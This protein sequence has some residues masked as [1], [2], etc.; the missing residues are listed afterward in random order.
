M[1]LLREINIFGA[2]EWDEDKDIPDLT[3]KVAI[4]TGGAGGCGYRAAIA[5]LKKNCKVIIASRSK[6]KADAAIKTLRD[7]IKTGDVSFIRVDLGDLKTIKPFAEE[8]ARSSSSLDI[9]INNAGVM[10]APDGSKTSDGYEL[11]I[12]TNVIGHFALFQALL[13]ILLVTARQTGQVRIVNVS[14]F[15]H[16]FASRPPITWDDD[17]FWFKSSGLRA[18]NARYAA[19]KAGNV[20]INTKMHES[21]G[22]HGLVCVS[23]HPGIINTDL[24]RQITGLPRWFLNQ[25]IFQPAE[26]GGINITCAATSPKLKGNEYIVP[27]GRVGKPRA[28]LKDYSLATETWN[29]LIIEIQSHGC[30]VHDK[31]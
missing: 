15:V 1:D 29:R 21:Y 2:T 4:I 20:L 6:D 23:C 17:K 16:R 31:T 9:L 28:Q 18:R 14:S 3:G 22:H 25:L 12:G 27:W 13:S 11:Q 26:K 30:Y 8:F 24:H 5:F 7:E 19:S 10:L